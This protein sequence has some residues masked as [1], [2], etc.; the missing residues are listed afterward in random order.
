[1]LGRENAQH[2]PCLRTACSPDVTPGWAKRKPGDVLVDLVDEIRA[3]QVRSGI[4][5]FACSTAMLNGA[6]QRQENSSARTLGRNT[7]IVTSDSI[8]RFPQQQ[9][10]ESHMN[11]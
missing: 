1:M 10:A 5:A 7:R 6:Q 4:V 3:L 11:A 9:I 2:G 8:L